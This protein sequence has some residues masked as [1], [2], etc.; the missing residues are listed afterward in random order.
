MH[1]AA[2]F[3]IQNS[4]LSIQKLKTVEFRDVLAYRIIWLFD[5]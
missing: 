5:E 3:V 1:F 2:L 4:L